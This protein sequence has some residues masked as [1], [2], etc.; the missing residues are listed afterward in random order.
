MLIFKNLFICL[1]SVVST[2]HILSLNVDI[3]GEQSIKITSIRPSFQ[4]NII[5]RMNYLLAHIIEIHLNK[6]DKT[7]STILALY[8]NKKIFISTPLF[9]DIANISK[10]W[11][12]IDSKRVELNGID[13]LHIPVNTVFIN[14]EGIHNETDIH[15]LLYENYPNII[16]II[17]SSKFSTATKDPQEMSEFFYPVN[18]EFSQFFNTKTFSGIKINVIDI[19]NLASSQYTDSFY[20]IGKVNNILTYTNLTYVLLNNQMYYF[21]SFGKVYILGIL[22]N[23]VFSPSDIGSIIVYCNIATCRMIGQIVYLK[24]YEATYETN[25]HLNINLPDHKDKDKF[26]ISVF[27]ANLY[28]D[29]TTHDIQTPIYNKFNHKS[30]PVNKEILDLNLTRMKAQTHVKQV[31]LPQTSKEIHLQPDE[32]LSSLDIKSRKRTINGQELSTAKRKKLDP[33]DETQVDLIKTLITETT[34]L[35]TKDS[36]PRKR[37]LGTNESQLIHTITSQEHSKPIEEEI[38]QDTTANSIPSNDRKEIKELTDKQLFE[39]CYSTINLFDIGETQSKTS[40]NNSLIPNLIN[41]QPKIEEDQPNDNGKNTQQI[42]EQD[43]KLIEKEKN[44]ILTFLPDR[45]IYKVIVVTG[46]EKTD[47]TIDVVLLDTVKPVIIAF[48]CSKNIVRPIL[49]TSVRNS[50]YLATPINQGKN[51]TIKKT[52]YKSEYDSSTLQNETYKPGGIYHTT[53]D[54]YFQVINYPKRRVIRE[55]YLKSEDNKDRVTFIDQEKVPENVLVR[56]F[57]N[58]TLDKKT[59]STLK[60]QRSKIVLTERTIRNHTTYKVIAYHILRMTAVDFINE[61]DRND[62]IYY[63]KDDKYF[64]VKNKVIHELKFKVESKYFS[65]YNWTLAIFLK[66]RMP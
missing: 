47:S 12:E 34:H 11:F 66:F 43:I 10:I 65:Q 18:S 38:G 23:N 63:T 59:I 24:N 39:D 26:R 55:M 60:K 48:K 14:L 9:G 33:K 45:D 62:G 19:S 51:F 15:K 7:S 57:E 41:P 64:E 6:K 29:E 52:F 3:Y 1:F 17:K 37:P 50:E 30:P 58:Y 22:K 40:D 35:E 36:N 28:A 13:K 8:Y 5:D 27:K 61:K 2:T 21:S 54:K 31:L 20:I 53:D 16:K 32:G 49:E 4:P 56:L 25:N 46:I 42:S 44:V